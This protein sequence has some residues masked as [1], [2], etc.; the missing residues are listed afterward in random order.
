MQFSLAELVIELEMMAT[1]NRCVV[2]SIAKLKVEV[3]ARPPGQPTPTIHR[4]DPATA[5]RGG[6]WLLGFPPGPMRPSLDDLETTA[7]RHDLHI[8][9]V[10]GVDARSTCASTVW[11]SRQRRLPPPGFQVAGLQAH[12]T[13]PSQWT[14]GARNYKHAASIANTTRAL[15]LVLLT[16]SRMY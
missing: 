8:D 6:F 12:A 4:R 1:G 7:L 3:A 5:P 16:N 13:T 9:A 15:V 10:L 2:H 14:L 11:N